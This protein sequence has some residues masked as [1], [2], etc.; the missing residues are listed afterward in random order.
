MRYFQIILGLDSN[1]SAPLDGVTVNVLK[2]IK[3]A[4]SPALSDIMK[5]C[6]CHGIFSKSLKVDKVIPLH[7]GG[8]TS[9]TSNYRPLSPLPQVSKV[10][11]KLFTKNSRFS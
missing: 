8:S 2:A 1:K 11:E 5:K 7:M 6:F 3:H 10:I 4:V 9:N